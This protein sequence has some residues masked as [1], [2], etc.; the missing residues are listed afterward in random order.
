MKCSICKNKATGRLSPDLDIGGVPFC[1][2]HK[3]S[4]RMGFMILRF[5]GIDAFDK[6]IANEKKIQQKN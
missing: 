3:E 2:Q 5:E 4:V 6:F 1:E